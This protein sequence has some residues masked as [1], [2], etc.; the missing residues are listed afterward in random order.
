MQTQSMALLSKLFEYEPEIPK[1][2]INSIIKSME[3]AKGEPF[4]SWYYR[5]KHA[6]HLCVFIDETSDVP[7]EDSR[8]YMSAGGEPYVSVDSRLKCIGMGVGHLETSFVKDADAGHVDHKMTLDRYEAS[9]A[10]ENGCLQYWLDVTAPIVSYLNGLLVKMGCDTLTAYTCVQSESFLEHF[11]R[12]YVEASRRRDSSGRLTRW[13]YDPPVFLDDRILV[14]GLNGEKK[15][16]KPFNDW[17][18]ESVLMGEVGRKLRS[19]VRMPPQNG[20]V[21]AILPKYAQEDIIRN[22]KPLDVKAE[23]RRK[24]GSI[25]A[26]HEEWRNRTLEK[27]EEEGRPINIHERRAD[28]LRRANRQA[29]HA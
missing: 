23:L 6:N 21:R 10:P 14:I 24:S 12:G 4:Q 15:S 2:D 9:F 20:M 13:E 28:K 5:Y 3:N 17:K 1:Y 7:A 29:P 16:K 26:A 22:H 27:D 8:P 19:R 25:S 18:Y 11:R